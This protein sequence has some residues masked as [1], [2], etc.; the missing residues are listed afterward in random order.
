M[1]ISSTARTYA[2]F[3]L[4]SVA[5]NE[6]MSAFFRH[7][8]RVRNFNA[9]KARAVATGRQLVVVGAP[10]NGL[11]TRII[12]A[13]DCGDVC[14]DLEGCAECPVSVEVDL[15]T[16]RVEIVEDDSAI[17]FVSCVLEYTSDP[18]AAWREIMRMGG[19]ADNVFL[20][21]VNATS[22]TAVLYPHASYFID[23]E[24][25]EISTTEVSPALKVAVVGGLLALGALGFLVPVKKPARALPP[26]G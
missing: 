23:Q 1:K 18:Q 6:G 12:P 2:R 13:Y 19:N 10:G 7:R 8:A 22:V 26:G 21:T 5:F 25:G 11:H 4:A 20:V 9:A 16:G 15:T 3:T 14:V 24:G 17:V